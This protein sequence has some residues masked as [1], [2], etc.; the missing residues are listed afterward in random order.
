MNLAQVDKI[1]NLI[2]TSRLL[3]DSERQEWSQ[4]ITLMNDKQISELGEILLSQPE[5]P[6]PAASPQI[7][8]QNLPPLRHISNLPSS[9]NLSAVPQ[10]K[11]PSAPLLQNTETKTVTSWP[12]KLNT[13]LQ[14]KELPPGKKMEE[15]LPT[16]V[17][18]MKQAP[19]RPNETQPAAQPLFKKTDNQF[20][21]LNRET[22]NV[23][24]KSA[25]APARS[26]PQAQPAENNTTLNLNSLAEISQLEAR[27]LRSIGITGLIARFRNL[28]I[29]FG[30]FDVL[31]AFEKSPLY[32]LYL[33]TGKDLLTKV[34]GQQKSPT[35][36]QTLPTNLLTKQEFEGITDLLLKIQLN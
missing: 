14:E 5:M 36:N 15:R 30:Y 22:I 31:F 3:S 4:L 6:K 2:K 9:I 7:P 10:T 1:K 24:Q 33:E 19:H 28:A 13:I 18:A 34:H 23:P 25:V 32:K 12:T 26:V 29:T 27:H 20:I 11:L 8:A 16:P 17:P 21:P 35:H